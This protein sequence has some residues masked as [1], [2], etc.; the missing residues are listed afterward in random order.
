MNHQELT[1]SEA[2]AIVRHHVHDLRNLLN[3][4]DLEVCCLMEEPAGS[5]AAAPLGKIRDQLARMERTARAL[6]IRFM[7]SSLSIAAA[8]DLFYNWRQQFQQQ[9][10]GPE[11]LWEEPACTAAITVDFSAV[12]TVLG[13]ICLQ[14]KFLARPQPLG[15]AILEEDGR[16]IFAIREPAPEGSSLDSAPESQQWLEWERLVMNS[17]GRLTRKY[18][19]AP[20]LWV[21]RLTFPVVA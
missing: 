3:C 4:L 8:V 18:E 19:E 6:S 14:M 1:P 9:G 17:G 5:A 21:T 12:V 16:V 15:A 13:E 10:Q 11:V 2:Q 20:A 7:D